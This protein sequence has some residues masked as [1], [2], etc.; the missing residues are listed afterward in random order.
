MST[1]GYALLA[2]LSTRPRTGYELAQ[3]MKRP[4]AHMWAA[5]H[6]QIYP[7]LRRL[8]Q[9]GWVISTVIAGPGPRDNRRYTITPGGLDAL[10]AWADSP[11]APEVPRS[12][13]LLRVRSLWLIG[14]ERAIAF[15]AEERRRCLE[16]LS[17]LD[18]EAAEFAPDDVLST[19]HPEFFAYAT[20]RYGVLRTKAAL[21]W[22]DWLLQQL[23]NGQPDVFSFPLAVDG[24][25]TLTPSP[26]QVP[27]AAPHTD[28][29][30]L[31]D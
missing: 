2:L 25:A 17:V 24:P 10:A 23:R 26:A 12:E 6:S 5:Q 27:L 28:H 14:P 1:L 31:G 9:A 19:G 4:I 22:W 21:A 11:L 3:R 13:M 30:T 18:Q 16:R 8:A 29:P 20:L 7:E 15:A